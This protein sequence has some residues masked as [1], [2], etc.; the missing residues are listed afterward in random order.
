MK[1]ICAQPA[2][3]YYAWQI[4]AMLFSFR[5]VGVNLEDVHVVCAIHGEINSHFDTLMRKYQGVIFSFY[6]D[7]RS[8]K[9][10]ISSIRPYILKQHFEVYKELSEE[11]LFYHDCDIVF[12]KP[13]EMNRFSA[14][15]VCYLSDT[16]S[17]I[18]Y[19]YIKSKGEDVFK[20]MIDIVGIDEQTVID[21]QESSGG[22]QYILKGIDKYFWHDVEKDAV[23]LFKEVTQMNVHKK[24]IDPNYHE[25]Q[26]WCADMWAVLWNIWKRNKTTKVVP[27]LDFSWATSNIAEWHMKS[28]YHNAGVT[29]SDNDMFFKGNY[30]NKMPSMDLDVSN[31]KCSYNYYK[32]I[33]QA[34]V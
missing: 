15:D 32:L 17:Y 33:Q 13:I 16:V 18:G 8:D 4:D 24:Q 5:T 7:N 9:S 25:I 29:A 20:K 11:V 19:N 26:I 23:R 3:L 10:Y 12:T 14:D 27:E 21:N 28:I 6:E 2:T 30:I 34:L 22:A 31:Q 1:Y